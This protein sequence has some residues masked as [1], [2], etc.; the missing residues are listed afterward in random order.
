MVA[1]EHFLSDMAWIGAQ[2]PFVHAPVRAKSEPAFGDL[3]IAP[4]AQVAAVRPF[5]EIAAIDPSAGHCSLRAHLSYDNHLKASPG[6]LPGG[7]GRIS[8]QYWWTSRGNKST[9]VDI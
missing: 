7:L 2:A 4:A 5:G 6:A 9:L 8:N 3:K 1:L